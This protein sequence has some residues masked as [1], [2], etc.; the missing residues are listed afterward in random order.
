[1]V[2]FCIYC[3]TL[4]K[5]IKVTDGIWTGGGRGGGKDRGFVEGKLGRGITFEM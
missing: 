5:I 3:F 1:L 2:R 4:V